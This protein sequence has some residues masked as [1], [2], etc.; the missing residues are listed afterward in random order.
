MCNAKNTKV[1]NIIKCRLSF[2]YSQNNSFSKS[3]TTAKIGIPQLSTIHLEWMQC[4]ILTYKLISKKKN[5]HLIWIR[6][7]GFPKKFQDHGE[8]DIFPQRSVGSHIWDDLIWTQC[9]QA[10]QYTVHKPMNHT[11]QYHTRSPLT[12]ICSTLKYFSWNGCLMQELS[13]EHN[14]MADFP[15]ISSWFLLHSS[16]YS[17]NNSLSKSQIVATTGIPK[18]SSMHLQQMWCPRLTTTN[19]ALS[20]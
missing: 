19:K 18:L 13:D 16:T 17:H 1:M 12:Q 11:W 14:K 5:G 10:M 15:H 6:M 7:S 4:L 20:H 3:L 8:T 9:I 2:T